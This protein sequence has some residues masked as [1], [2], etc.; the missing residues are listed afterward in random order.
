[1]RVSR[2][3]GEQTGTQAFSRGWNMCLVLLQAFLV[4]CVCVGLAAG[5]YVLLYW[6]TIPIKTYEF[7]LYFEFR[8]G[9]VGVVRRRR[10]S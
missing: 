6:Y 7:P 10:R 1:M 5:S 3:H 8:C 4:V 2:T 9:G